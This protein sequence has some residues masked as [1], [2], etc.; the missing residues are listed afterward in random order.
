MQ[1]IFLLKYLYF[2]T[3]YLNK[4]KAILKKIM[5]IFILQMLPHLI[6]L[7]N[8]SNISVIIFILSLLKHI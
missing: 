8:Y 4:Y 1:S 3:E 2:I 6:N 7:F 5:M